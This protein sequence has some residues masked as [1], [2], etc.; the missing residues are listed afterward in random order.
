[1]DYLSTVKQVVAQEFESFQSY[2]AS[3]FVSENP[4]LQHVLT[5]LQSSR[6][7]MLR[8]ILAILT[9]KSLGKTTN[10]TYRAASALE[11]L[12]TASLLHD[13]VVDDSMLR[14]GNPSVNATFN[15]KLSILVGDYLLS[16]SLRQVTL[17][18]RPEIVDVI[19]ELGQL[20]SSGEIFQLSNEYRAS[21]SS[22]LYYK[23]IQHKTASFFAAS[24]AVGALSVEAPDDEVKRMKSFGEKVGMCFQIRDDIFDFMG[25]S[26]IGKPTG[27]DIME[28]KLTLPAIYALTHFA[29]S[30]TDELVQKM[31]NDSLTP[32]EIQFLID[33]TVQNGGITY[34]EKVMHDFRDEALSYLPSALTPE[35]SNALVAFVDFAIQRKK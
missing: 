25:D 2:Y 15:N 12:H 31:K 29:T 11:L 35:N 22:E 5:Y 30:R 13:D 19:S 17:S 1:M 20:L 4:L 3:L 9:A 34:A 23:V 28:G 33:F 8:P 24:G 14:H 26:S 7:K 21:L 18:L 27:N 10:A 6:G 32:Q 16:S